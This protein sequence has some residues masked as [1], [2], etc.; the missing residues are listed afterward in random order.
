MYQNWQQWVAFLPVSGLRAWAVAA[1]GRVG[2]SPEA[3]TSTSDGF[4]RVAFC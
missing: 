3:A 1:M 4:P 2:V